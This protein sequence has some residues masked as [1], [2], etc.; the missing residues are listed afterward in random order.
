VIASFAVG[1]AFVAATTS[2]ASQAGDE[3]RP[4]T[5]RSGPDAI[6]AGP[7]VVQVPGK[8]Q[9]TLPVSQVCITLPAASVRVNFTVTLPDALDLLSLPSRA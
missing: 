6:C 3:R 4:P 1:V 2:S 7:A 9:L 8:D 5:S